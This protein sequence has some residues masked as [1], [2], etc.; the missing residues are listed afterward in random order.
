MNAHVNGKYLI[1]S[2]LLFMYLGTW[3]TIFYVKIKYKKCHL[4]EILKQ[5]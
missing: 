2:T 4:V 3:K 1:L 5:N